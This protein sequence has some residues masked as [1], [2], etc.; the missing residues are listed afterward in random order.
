MEH[1]LM[2]FVL[3]LYHIN[4]H[5]CMDII[6][7][8]EAAPHSRP[9]MVF[10][11]GN[12][13]CGG[14]LIKPNWVL[15]AAHCDVG[16]NSVAI[17]GAHR[18]KNIGE[19]QRL[20]VKR[21]IKYPCYD[22][23]LRIHDIQLLQLEKPAKLN[24]F[25]AVI[26]LPKSE[27]NVTTG[28]VCSAAGWGNTV[29][30][31]KSLSEVLREVN[32]EIVDNK[33]CKEKYSKEKQLITNSMMCAGPLKK[34]KDDTCQG[35]SGGPLIYEKKYVGIVSFGPIT[36]DNPNIPGVYTRLTNNY[37]KWIRNTIGGDYSETYTI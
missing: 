29:P 36:C 18:L 31:K 6:G 23:D 37:L 8:N 17:L 21:G 16:N 26:A 2:L 13:Y 34:R 10:L 25:V 9:Y 28:K 20:R 11:E 35:D 14:A 7:G 19:Q 27:E 32:L 22:P 30:K 1:L 24:K 12:G 33:I 4:G 3:S 5:V 15:T